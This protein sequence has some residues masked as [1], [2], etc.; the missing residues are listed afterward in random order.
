MPRVDKKEKQH[1]FQHD[2]Y[3]RNDTKII[4]LRVFGGMEAYGIFFA[5]VE[6]LHEHGGWMEYDPKSI[7]Y[8]LQADESIVKHVIEDFG[9]FI[10][11]RSK[12]IFSSGRV[13]QNIAFVESKKEI[14]KK[15]AEK[16]LIPDTARAAAVLDDELN[17]KGKK[18]TRKKPE[19]VPSNGSTI[20]E[21]DSAIA[22]PL[23]NNSLAIVPHSNNDNDS[24]RDNDKDSDSDSTHLAFTLDSSLISAPAVAGAEPR[25][26]LPAGVFQ[27]NQA[28][29]IKARPDVKKQFIEAHPVTA[30][31]DVPASEGIPK[32]EKI[33]PPRLR[34]EASDLAQYFYAEY[35][36]ARGEQYFQKNFKNDSRL[37]HDL[38]E[39][40]MTPE[41]VKGRIDRLFASRDSFIMSSTYTLGLFKASLAKLKYDSAASLGDAIL[42]RSAKIRADRRVARAAAEAA[43]KK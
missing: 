27:D 1:Y 29:Q 13:L 35:A 9:L 40:G 4:K 32:Q 41:D 37:F 23:L 26:T 15:N 21:Q 10:F 28:D 42:A 16:R 33:G 34:P 25:A 6:L 8:E 38:L 43:A 14:Y 17:K 24:D 36:K 20:A 3:A 31:K 5:V 18:T 2:H 19:L 11:R 7:S 30:K 22:E 39:A 12:K